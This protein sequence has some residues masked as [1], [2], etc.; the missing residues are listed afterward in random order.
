VHPGRRVV[1][2]SWS[3]SAVSDVDRPPV[4]QLLVLHDQIRNSVD[5]ESV[6]AAVH[7]VEWGRW[8]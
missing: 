7:A 6:A 8:A 1:D 4:P 3:P 2:I 5:L